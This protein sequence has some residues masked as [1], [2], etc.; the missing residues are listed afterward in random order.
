[1]K[2]YATTKQGERFL[3]YLECD[4]CDARIRPHPEI[5][6]SGWTKVGTYYGPGDDRNVESDLCPDHSRLF[7]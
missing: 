2:V 5:A 1:M 4:R 7:A 3:A 6:K